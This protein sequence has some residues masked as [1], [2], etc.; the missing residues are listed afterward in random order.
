MKRRSFL[1]L[2]GGAAAAWPLAARAQRA[3]A[4]KRIGYLRT[5]GENDPVIESSYAGLQHHRVDVQ[6]VVIA[7]TRANVDLKIATT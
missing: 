1:T 3:N 2:L 6:A 4:V 5:G 7:A